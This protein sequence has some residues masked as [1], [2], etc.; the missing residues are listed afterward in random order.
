MQAQFN[1][2]PLLSV[3][4][5]LD[6]SLANISRELED[7]F[8][9]GGSN[10]EALKN[11]QEEL[12]R[13]GGVL[14][15]LSL[16]GLSVFCAELEKQLQEFNQPQDITALRRD[17]IRRA[18][19]GLTHY[20]DALAD[21]AT[22]ATLRLFH[23]YQEMLQA[24]GVEMAFDVDLFFPS[25]QVELP[26]TL[27]Q[28]PQD[29]EAAVH[30]KSAR[31]Q[32][33]QAL[34]KWL[35][36]DNVPESLRMMMAAVRAAFACAPQNL[37]RGFWWVAAG[38]LD[39]LMH[40]GVPPELNVRKVLSRIDLKMKSL[41]DGSAFDEES[42]ISEMLYLIARSHSVSDAVEQV[43]RVY[44]LDVYLPEEPP[45]PPSETAA[46]LENMRAQLRLAQEVWEQCIAEEAG[47]CQRFGEEIAKLHELSEHLDRNTLQFLCKQIQ[48]SAQHAD[49]PERVQRMSME[50][51]MALLLLEGG[52]EHYRHLGSGF[53]EQTRI[54]SARLQASAMR[55]PEDEGKFNNLVS[56]Y[57]QMEQ[58]EAMVPLATEM[59]GNL[60]LIEQSLNAFFNNS[61]KRADLT[62]IGRLL[63][64]VQGGLHI[65]SLE[66]AV[67]LTGMLRQVSERYVQGTTPPAAEMRTV[68]AAISALEEYVH[69]L[70]L[71]QKPD[72]SALSSVLQE[73]TEVRAASG[74]EDI[75]LPEEEPVHA[76][77]SIRTG[78]EDEELLEVFLEEARE[79]METLRSNL[80]ISRLHMDSREPLVT[81]RRSFHTLKGSSRMVGLAELGEVAWAVERAMNKWLQDNKPAT[82]E[83]LDMIGD[84]EVLFQHWVDMLHSGSASAT[85]DTSWLLTVADC[86]EN[87]KEI[88]QPEGGRSEQPESTETVVPEVEEGPVEIGSVSLSLMLFSIATEEAAGH[89]EA[90]RNQLAVLHETESHIVTYDFMR[91]AHTLAGV[92]RTMGFVQIAELAYALE[93]WLEE[94]IDKP[95]VV[96]DEQ[97]A[98]IDKV[99]ERLDEMC[100]LVREQRQEPQPQP[101]LIGLL[102]AD[103]SL[104]HIDVTPAPLDLELPELPEQEIETPAVVE[105]LPVL[106]FDLPETTEEHTAV[107][108]A[109][110]AELLSEITL[111][112]APVSAE[113]LLEAPA[114]EP[115][116][117]TPEVMLDFA[118]P[119]ESMPEAVETTAPAEDEEFATTDEPEP[120]AAP[121]QRERSV[122]DEIDEQLL[123]IFLEEAHELYPQIGTTL[124]AWREKPNDAQ[125]GRNLQRSLHTLK[126]SARMAGAMRLGELTHRVEDRVESALAKGEFSA[127]LWSE[128]DNYQDRIGSAI[129]QLQQPHAAEPSAAEPSLAEQQA[130]LEITQ[131]ISKQALEIGAERAMQAALLRV[132]SDTVDRLVN[133]AGEVSVARSR[134]E[135]EL[136]EFKNNV[137]ELTESV[138]RLR[139]QVREIEIHAEGQMQARIS[140]SGD[141]AEKFDPLEFDRFTRFQEL[142]R[143]MNESVH[144]VQTVQQTLLKNL[145]ETEA[146]LSAQA[147]LNRDLQQ[148]L[149]NIRMVPFSSISERLYRIVRQ[150]GKELG[151][152]ANLDLSGTE[153]E[154]DR[155]VLEKMTAPFE[156]LL[157]NAVAHGLETPE[158]RERA[159]KEPIGEIRLSLQQESNE[160]VFEL[161]DDGAGLDIARVR[162][163]AVENGVLQ[164]G[165]EISDELAMQLIFTP[166]LSTASE[167]TEI[168]GRGVGLD[169]VRSEIT[170]LGG[171]VDVSSE[172][173]RGVRFTIHLPLTLA[174]SKVL[175]IRAGQNVYALPSIMIEN[176]QQLK[177]AALEASYKQQYVEWQ[178]ARYPLHYLARLLGDDDIEVESLPHNPV[179][180]LRAGEHRIAVHVDELRGNQEVVVKNIGPQLARLPG[181]AGATVSG[182]GTV[183]LIINPVAFTQRIVVSRKIAKAEA[184]AVHKVPVVM[185]VDDSLTVRKITSRLLARSG[186]QVL[187]AKDGVDAMEQLTEVLPDIMLLD[188]EMPR[189]DGFELA[190]RMRQD[191]RTKDLPIIMITSRTAD[192]H[193]RYAL[194]LGVNEYMGKPYHEEELLEHIA[195]LVEAFPVQ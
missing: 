152:R 94:R 166:G 121:V 185:V 193:R 161:S 29:S 143:F 41:T 190:K 16:T 47:A 11:A 60:Q 35:R 64:Q 179:L 36:Q 89:V 8:S 34:L 79:V 1:T 138:N 136:S 44:M 97:I 22:N 27:L 62:H 125:L 20:L 28:V 15:M 80:E 43:K 182:N 63:S 58:H 170:A 144:D 181:I 42:A 81:M 168:S 61:A 112:F 102:Q 195:R 45:L 26:E 70:V 57:C 68:A 120:E 69:G 126:G 147:Q 140:I 6:G 159:G 132:R 24:R 76:G 85:I 128:L 66:V 148:G 53:H 78:G 73:M 129:E 4:P 65:L 139:K 172:P 9:S 12:H 118:L 171:R 137:Q 130:Q 71:G 122:H 146:A 106:D 145:A 96:N 177:P 113:I 92:N 133:E 178:G 110:E 99:V 91:A 104:T 86:I 127:A 155:S 142:T 19:F 105:E 180:L 88:P 37:Q 55:L 156:H 174:V 46:L 33:Q 2:L 90:L 10:R 109:A 14:R 164:E 153:V 21:G 51:A 115:E 5:G 173:G 188:V 123:P 93:L 114:A 117:A 124:R 18:L 111:D 158:L 49:D 75:A 162:E 40:E 13:I 72:P 54:L 101:D 25:L 165:E 32:F 163:K 87:G 31:M 95:H 84:A 151:K 119:T 131:T 39:C 169:V 74:Q 103:R 98:L 175:M 186:Y 30:I 23:E 3:K 135:L 67:Q 77:V 187:T 108:Q 52:I 191:N 38:L 83:L 189:M 59:Q 176:V 192:K 149:M 157:R 107:E 17:V 50:M 100:A 167:I 7:F 82:P 48:T 116:P 56:L 154:L 150:T 134:I 141:S 184:A 194:E 160:V 183:I